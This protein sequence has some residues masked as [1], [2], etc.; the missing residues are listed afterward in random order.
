MWFVCE[1]PSLL[2]RIALC[3]IRVSPSLPSTQLTTL[4]KWFLGL[5]QRWRYAPHKQTVFWVLLVSLIDLV[6]LA[7]NASVKKLLSIAV[8]YT[9]DRDHN[10]DT[11]VLGCFGREMLGTLNIYASYQPRTRTSMIRNK[12]YNNVSVET[13]PHRLLVGTP[14][15]HQLDESNKL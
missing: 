14:V 6:H 12:I 3:N 1:I 4:K 11:W 9:V 2:T 15:V 10:I 13:W 8:L 7:I 5:T